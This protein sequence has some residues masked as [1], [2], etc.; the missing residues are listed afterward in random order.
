MIDAQMKK[1]GQ[2]RDVI[3]NNGAVPSK[4]SQCYGK[5]THLRPIGFGLNRLPVSGDFR[6]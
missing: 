3:L 5:A 2:P 1:Q 4:E 6:C